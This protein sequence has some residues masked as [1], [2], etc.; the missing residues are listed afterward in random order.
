MSRLLYHLSYAAKQCVAEHDR[1]NY[2]HEKQPCQEPLIG[3]LNRKPR[4]HGTGEQDLIQ[5]LGKHK[6]NDLP[7]SPLLFAEYQIPPLRYHLGLFYQNWNQ[8]IIGIYA[9]LSHS[10]RGW[11]DRCK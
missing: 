3:K 8:G 2:T 10:E 6:C 7:N 5:S 1:R 9:R 11:Q 4:R